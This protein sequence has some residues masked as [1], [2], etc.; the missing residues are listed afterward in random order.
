MATS[1]PNTQSYDFKF[2]KA[3]R[4]CKNLVK[5]EYSNSISGILRS[6]RSF[7]K[8]FY[9]MHLSGLLSIYDDINYEG[10][11]L[12][13]P[14]DSGFIMTDEDMI[15]ME[16]LTAIDII[17]RHTINTVVPFNLL[18]NS[19]SFVLDTKHPNKKLLISHDIK[20]TPPLVKINNVT[21]LVLQDI[22]AANGIIHG[23]NSLLY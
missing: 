18:L 2:L 14:V 17:K 20:K 7:S 15:Q 11:T 8:F 16:K 9:I 12:F 1:Y 10:T 13:V 4:P 22:I 6:T 21:T 19:A 3:T 23:I 5:C